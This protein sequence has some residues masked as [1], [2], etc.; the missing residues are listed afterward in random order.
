M[1]R[2]SISGHRELLNSDEVSNSIAS[3]FIELKKRDSHLLAISALAAGADTLFAQEAIK[4]NI[5]LQ[6][7]L[8]FTLEKYK[9]DFSETEKHKLTDLMDARKVE[10]A[11][12]L[13]TDDSEER[14]KAYL[15][16]GKLIVSKS[17]VLIAVWDGWSANGTGGTGDI[18]DYARQQ[19]K[20][21]IV[22]NGLRSNDKSN[23]DA[24]STFLLWDNE[25]IRYKGRFE[26]TWITGL[27]TGVLAVFCFATGMAFFH[28]GN[29]AV[30]FFLS[31]AEAIFLLL[32]FLLLTISARKF[33][34]V[35]LDKRRGAEF[36]RTLVR[37]RN[38]GIPI[39]KIN[40]TDYV[41][42]KDILQIEKQI[43]TRLTKIENLEN[44][45]AITLALANEQI[46]Y[47]NSFRI[48]KFEK[49]EAFLEK[50]FIV[51][52]CLFVC[53]LLSILYV[54][55]PYKEH[56]SSHQLER[57]LT[58]GWIV[59]PPIYAALEGIKYFSEWKSNISI[60]R[61]TIS[62]LEN[63]VSRIKECK[64][65]PAFSLIAKDLRDILEFE[66]NDWAVRKFELD[67]EFK[68]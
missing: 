29:P 51:I 55:Y 19:H 25:A 54:E 12:Q 61:K 38:A 45:K 48:P 30:K 20:E 37:F 64:T 14:N 65:E 58:F 13:T 4:Q 2:I 3:T 57:W 62:F 52:K 47:H 39:P 17:D 34:K 43:S 63:I 18:V 44:A 31:C 35:F 16:T 66:N 6:V 68:P 32:S 26:K 33:K 41:P 8:P 22:I 36:L 1:I 15:E 10:V 40:V 28:E 27:F 7:I 5:P 53:L 60:S 59:L 23:D 11:F 42:A 56:H 24:N 9:N 46:T 50:L 21:I 67:P 49:K